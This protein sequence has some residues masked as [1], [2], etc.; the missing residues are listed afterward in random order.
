[1]TV[2]V[3][4][5]ADCTLLVDEEPL[6][7]PISEGRLTLDDG[8]SP[9]VQASLTVPLTDPAVAEQIEPRQAQRVTV[10]ASVQGHWESVGAGVYGAGVYGA[11]VYGGVAATVW[12]SDDERTFDLGLRE[13]TIHHENGTIDLNLA[14]DEALLLDRKNVSSTVDDDPLADA[15]S[16]RDVVSWALAKVGAT[17]E[18][19]AA[20]ADLTPYWSQTNLIK[21]PA[22][23]V[24]TTNWVNGSGSNTLSRVTGLSGPPR[25]TGFRLAWGSGGTYWDMRSEYL[26]VNVGRQYNI[27][28]NVR[29]STSRAIRF[30]LSFFEADG[31]TYN[32][33]TET[34]AEVT[35]GT[36][37]EQLN[38]SA[39]A[40]AR[41]THARIIFRNVATGS[42]GQWIEGTAFKFYEGV[43]VD[44]SYFDGDTADDAN[45]TYA[46]AGD[47]SD[48]ASERN[49]VIERP[50]ELFY[51]KPG[52]ALWD[53]LS[54]LLETSGLRLFC[55]EERTW[56]LVDPG[57]YEVEGFTV[58]QSGH[59][60][61]A[62]TDRISRN[63]E[64]WADAVVCVYRWTDENGIQ[65]EAYDVAGD[66]DGKCETFEYDREYPGPGA[67]EYLL[68]RLQGRGRIQEAT[69]LTKLSTT[70]GN[71]VLISL[72]GSNPQTGKVRQVIFDLRTGLMEVGTRGLTDALPGSWIT[73]DADE[74]WAE[75]DPDL[76]W[77]EA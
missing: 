35:T 26:P 34:Y 14:S 50:R 25:S 38:V 55:D 29:A 74:T 75:V 21:N 47:A 32:F 49:A 9:Y 13:R 70:P 63:A 76:T 20:D 52:V 18:A 7:L 8:H 1:M 3:K 15:D 59:N 62:G 19:G 44:N 65:R 69:A 53:F 48:S 10:T 6:S 37:W 36:T 57:T 41:A 11:G 31:S 12:V 39:I 30:I 46:W 73:W 27:R 68:G 43:E 56:R 77:T 17:L 66:P 51:W 54:P 61:T 4:P 22:A 23:I 28:G 71:D 72:P 5:E 42:S 58:V 2:F 67:A 24:D 60:A 45:Y 40:P 64:T 33:I 16:L